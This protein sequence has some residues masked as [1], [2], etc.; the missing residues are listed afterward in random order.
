MMEASPTRWFSWDY[1]VLEDGRPV[2]LLEMSSWRERGQF[3]VHGD[4]YEV[5]REGLI[6]GAFELSGRGDVLATAVKPSAFRSR[7]VLDYGRSR[8]VLKTRSAF[9]REMV[10]LEDDEVVGTLKPRGVF[11]RS[12]AINLPTVLPMPVKVFIVGLTVILW[13]RYASDTSGA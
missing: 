2:C 10:L 1:T 3:E 8:Y 12:M 5:S 4:D 11:S 7:F 9:R 6:S 13:K